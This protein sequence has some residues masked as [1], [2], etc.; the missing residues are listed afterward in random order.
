MASF[1]TDRVLFGSASDR[2][3]RARA[4]IDFAL[5]FYRHLLRHLAGAPIDDPLSRQIAGNA[6]AGNARNWPTESVEASVG[7][8]HDALAEV[9]ANLN[10]ANVIPCWLDD[11]SRLA[12]GS[13]VAAG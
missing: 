6:F 4:V 1:S 2:R 5:E 3:R 8:C 13:P 12:A 9:D 10:L 7:R 11:L